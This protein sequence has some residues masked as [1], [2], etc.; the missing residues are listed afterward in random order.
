LDAKEREVAHQRAEREDKLAA[1]EPPARRMGRVRDPRAEE[2]AFLRTAIEMDDQAIG[3]LRADRARLLRELGDPDQVRSE[4]D[5]IES[6]ITELTCD[7]DR[8]RDVLA[9]QT[10]GRRPDWLI[11]AL[12]ERPEG[13]RERETWDQA[14]RAVA[15]FRLDHDVIDHDGPLGPEPSGGGYEG[16]EWAQANAALEQAQRLL[17][18]E[19]AERGRGVDLGIG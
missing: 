4:R 2:R 15:G 18:R 11:R 9:D 1:L 8:V 3:D 16:R 13:S 10:I 12:G 7:H 5:G 6:A 17:G 14:A 19:P